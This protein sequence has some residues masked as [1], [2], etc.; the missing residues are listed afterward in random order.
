MFSHR[1]S[2]NK[3]KQRINPKGRVKCSRICWF[4]IKSREKINYKPAV[5]WHDKVFQCANI[6]QYRNWYHLQINTFNLNIWRPTFGHI[7]SL[8]DFYLWFCF[9]FDMEIYLSFSKCNVNENVDPI[10]EFE[11]FFFKFIS[12]LKCDIWRMKN[13]GNDWAV[14]KPFG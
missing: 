1:V 8:W 10:E 12:F 11:M 14:A 5:L 13:T 9:C 6:F 2:L 4:I 3:H 7:R